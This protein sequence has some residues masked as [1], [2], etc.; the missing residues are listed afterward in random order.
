MP[1]LLLS[2]RCFLRATRR[3][4]RGTRL[5]CDLIAEVN[6]IERVF[7]RIVDD[8]HYTLENGA[9]RDY[10]ESLIGILQVHAEPCPG[11][12]SLAGRRLGRIS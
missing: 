1:P 2:L 6:V 11:C 3:G 7:A 4:G 10:R 5:T 8:Q 9:N 12:R